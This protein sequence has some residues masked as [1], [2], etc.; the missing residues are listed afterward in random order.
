MEHFNVICFMVA[1]LCF[2]KDVI[3]Q[4]A[5]TSLYGCCQCHQ[6]N[7]E[8]KRLN[9]MKENEYK[10]KTM[11]ELNTNGVNALATLSKEPDRGSS[12]FTKFQHSHA[13]Q[14]T[15]NLF[16]GFTTELM[17]PCGLHLILANHRYIGKFLF[18]VVSK[19]KMEHLIPSVLR[20]IGC[21]YLAYQLEQYH[22][23]NKKQYDGS[24]KLKM[25]G[26]DCKLLEEN[27]D[28]LLDTFIRAE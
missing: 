4:C 12:K 10:T 25:I 5:C 15:T 16:K 13:G 26:N 21:G 17:P 23:S 27:V 28:A 14:W 1:D 6:K 8:W 24:D 11:S 19:R 9:R 2:V 7:T 18:D 3:G 22:K 20:K